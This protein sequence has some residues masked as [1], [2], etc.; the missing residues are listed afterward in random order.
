LAP[1]SH[2]SVRPFLWARRAI[3]ASSIAKPQRD[4][5][6]RRVLVQHQPTAWEYQ[7]YKKVCIAESN[8][9]TADSAKPKHKKRH[10][11]SACPL[12][13]RKPAAR[14]V[15]VLTPFL[16]RVN[17]GTLAFVMFVAF[18]LLSTIHGTESET[19][20][21]ASV[22][23]TKNEVAIDNFSFSPGTLTVPVGATVTWTNHDNVPHVVTSADNQFE[24]SHLLKAGQRF[25]NTFATAG[26]YSYFC[27]IHPRMTGKIIVK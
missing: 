6:S 3:R 2:N 21:L 27:S 14:C 5:G 12:H 4:V 11:M 25:S 15:T 20:E 7:R 8:L 16:R 1:C 18:A 17:T 24:K 19:K 26:T 9:R 10:V 23:A 13:Y 22:K